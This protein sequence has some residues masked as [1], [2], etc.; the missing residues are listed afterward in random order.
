[1]DLD[2]YKD[3]NLNSELSIKIRKLDNT[4]PDAMRKS[5]PVILTLT[6]FMSSCEPT[7]YKALE[8]ETYTNHDFGWTIQIPTGWTIVS[9]DKFDLEFIGV[10]D[11]IISKVGCCIL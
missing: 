5:I 1:L 9:K 8:G 10:K 6:V 11:L 2:I 3:A 7:P 4:N